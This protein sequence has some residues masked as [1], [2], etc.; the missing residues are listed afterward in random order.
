MS[1]LCLGPRDGWFWVEEA[2]WWCWAAFL[3]SKYSQ[4]ARKHGS[5]ST[6]EAFV[7][8]NKLQLNL[9]NVLLK[10][11]R[12][13]EGNI[14]ISLRSPRKRYTIK[15]GSP[16][17]LY[18]DICVQSVNFCVKLQFSPWQLSKNSRFNW[19]ISFWTL[20]DDFL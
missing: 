13:L 3:E 17:F 19:F 14:V 5:C 1:F 6:G 18:N 4:R 10:K 15:L 8:L 2:F 9:N 20:F 12:R 7:Y 16:S 11:Q